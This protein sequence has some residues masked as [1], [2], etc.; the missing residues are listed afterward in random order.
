[1]LDRYEL[2]SSSFNN[3]QNMLSISSVTDTVNTNSHLFVSI[4]TYS[5]VVGLY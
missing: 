4:N 1:M 2:K 5:C 3:F